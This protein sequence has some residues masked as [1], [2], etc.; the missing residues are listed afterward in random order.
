MP[1]ENRPPPIKN[2]L[3]AALPDKEYERLRP[4]LKSF[5]LPLGEVLYNAGDHI[6]YV[7]FV[8]SGVVSF[9]TH[10]HDGGSI[11]VGLVGNE[12]MVGVGIA[13][14]DN[15]APSEAIVQIA[16][17]GERMEAEV[18]REELK[19]DGQFQSL[20]LRYAQALMRQVSQTAACNRSHHVGERLARWLLTCQ[21]RAGSDKLRL[22]HEFI[23]EMLGVRRAGVT[24]AAIIL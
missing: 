8:K 18:L 16:D 17:G 19:R 10:M 1:T 24:E 3:L 7:Y 21:D 5:D 4:H 2:K 22:T 11:E 13:L 9:V 14:G 12:G 20:L 23:A 6:R 15:I